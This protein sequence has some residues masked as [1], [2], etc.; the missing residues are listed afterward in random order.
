MGIALL[1]VLAV[2]YFFVNY[3]R[4]TVQY[5][6][7]GLEIPDAVHAY[8]GRVI[9]ITSHYIVLRALS[10]SN[11]LEEDTELRID[12]TS[13]TKIVRYSLPKRVPYEAK[14]VEAHETPITVAD[15]QEGDMVEVYTDANSRGKSIFPADVIRV[16]EL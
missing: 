16:I 10:E 2:L 14:V 11:Y 15:I 13:N 7:T 6:T 1:A 3:Q 5:T 9:E 8:G 4:R 12:I